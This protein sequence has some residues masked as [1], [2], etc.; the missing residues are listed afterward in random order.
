MKRKTPNE[1]NE[2]HFVADGGK[3]YSGGKAHW[4]DCLT[5]VLGRYRAFDA[6]AS[7]AMQLQDQK[8]EEI[9]FSWCGS[10]E[11]D[12]EMTEMDWYHKLDMLRSKHSFAFTHNPGGGEFYRGDLRC[13]ISD[14]NYK[15]D[16][17][18]FVEW[19]KEKGLE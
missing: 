15:E 1:P 11:H 16:Y 9:R 3:A 8:R 14:Q 5:I 10:L 19:L 13:Q 7:L 12:D 4:P 17:E 6:L 18:R 2:W